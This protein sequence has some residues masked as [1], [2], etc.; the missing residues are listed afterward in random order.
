MASLSRSW[1]CAHVSTTQERLP[2][3]RFSFGISGPRRRRIPATWRIPLLAHKNRDTTEHYVR[4]R[5][6]E[7]VKPLR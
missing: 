5:I 4:S 7:R 2:V 1:H 3:C 6:G